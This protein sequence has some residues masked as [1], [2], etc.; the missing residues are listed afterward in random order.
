MSFK[1]HRKSSSRAFDHLYDPLNR[2]SIPRAQRLNSKSISKTAPLHI[3]PCYSSMFSDSA[4][5]PRN[6]YF[7]QRNSLPISRDFSSQTSCNRPVD[8]NQFFIP[9]V[10]DFGE[11]FCRDEIEPIPIVK[12]SITCQTIYR[13]S[14]A[15]TDCWLPDA[16][17]REDENCAPEALTVEI[18][19]EPGV[20]EV[21]AIERDRQQRDWELQL[22]QVTD[23]D[24]PS[25]ISQLEAFEW[26]KFLARERSMNEMQAD[27]QEQV[28]EMIDERQQMNSDFNRMMLENVKKRNDWEAERQKSKL[29]KTLSRKLGV[30]HG[31]SFGKSS[32][33]DKKF[34]K[35]CQPSFDFK[36]I[37]EELLENSKLAP[38]KELSRKPRDLSTPKPKLLRGLKPEKHLKVLYE[39]VKL[40]NKQQKHE[41]FECRR[42]IAA[43]PTEPDNF[44][45]QSDEAD[46]SDVIEV[47]KT[48]KGTFVQKKLICGMNDA[49]QSIQDVRK[50]LKIES[51]AEILPNNVVEVKEPP[52]KKVEFDLN[53]DIRG[54]VEPLVDE[55][56]QQAEDEAAAIANLQLLLEAEMRRRAYIE[57]K[58]REQ[59]L[60]E[61]REEIK[62]AIEDVQKTFADKVLKNLMPTVIEM[63]SEEDALKF[64]ENEARKIDDEACK[65]TENVAEIVEKSLQ[66]FV[67]P[68][69]EK[70]V[71]RRQKPDARKV[72]MV[73]AY[74]SIEDYLKNYKNAPEEADSDEESFDEE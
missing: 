12:R 64:I 50:Q 71:E 56:L 54:I 63:I 55:I 70:R 58:L 38:P 41:P 15:Q 37:R 9:P 5:R 2:S 47:Q 46:F 74:D 14:S 6:F 67:V 22:P 60:Q 11:V 26:Q 33:F 19:A 32:K 23:K 68:E 53:E 3:I 18:F 29:Q 42:K 72:A 25:R 7:H 65:S 57:E 28:A 20:R 34:K 13:E 48:I 62:S 30:L 35:S 40:A 4:I 39:S 1:S 24:F 66:D 10:G 59:K 16:K 45:F 36:A 73:A 69:V 61:R 51:V 27:R 17:V 31:E 21:E 52:P 43:S 8:T 44:S 49:M